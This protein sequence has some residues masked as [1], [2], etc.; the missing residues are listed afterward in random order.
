MTS[1][2]NIIWQALG[3]SIVIASLI[4]F[5]R[6]LINH[7]DM[8]PA[9]RWNGRTYLILFGSLAIY[10]LH[11]LLAAQGWRLILS[12]LGSRVAFAATFPV[13]LISQFGKYIP[14]NIAHHLGRV[15]LAKQIGLPIRTIVPSMF[16]ELGILV[17]FGMLFFL[18]FS[19]WGAANQL[20]EPLAYSMIALIVFGLPALLPRLYVRLLQLLPKKWQEVLPDIQF[21][22]LT[23]FSILLLYPCLFLTLGG[24]ISLIGL[25]EFGK[26]G[27][28][29]A[30]SGIFAVSWLAGFLV[31]GAP[32]GLGIREAMLI[33]LLEPIYGAGAALSLTILFRIIGSVGDFLG[34]LFGM[35]YY[36]F[37][38]KENGS[39][40]TGPSSNLTN[41]G[42]L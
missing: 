33:T 22:P 18:T 28:L 16:I 2:L 25:F 30:V 12:A 19:P 4:F 7:I 36:K 39:H 35:A 38:F 26:D 42:H 14:G 5:A 9:L 40:A 10:L 17:S 31:P 8:M 6:H 23:I 11:L 29:L 20:P 32:A 24:I 27:N 21:S 34:F 3:V 15:G 37:K 13:F 41:K 1:R